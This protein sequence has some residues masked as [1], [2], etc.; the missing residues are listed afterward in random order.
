MLASVLAVTDRCRISP[1][2]PIREEPLKEPQIADPRQ[3]QLQCGHRL[4]RATHAGSCQPGE[5]AGS[6]RPTA[7]AS[8]LHIGNSDRAQMASAVPLSVLDKSKRS[9]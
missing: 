2:L 4:R 5:H 6:H 9:K 1:G 3:L 8:G 7:T